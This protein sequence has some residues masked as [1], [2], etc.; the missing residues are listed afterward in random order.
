VYLAVL[1]IYF[2]SAAV[3]LLASLALIVQ[4]SLRVRDP[5]NALLYLYTLVH[6]HVQRRTIILNVIV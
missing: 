5:D 2:T 3:I 6:K 4:G 1:L